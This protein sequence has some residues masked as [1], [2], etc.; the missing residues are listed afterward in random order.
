MIRKVI[1]KNF[2]RF[3]DIEFELPGHV[4]IAGPNNTGKTTFLQALASW[5][6]AF[7]RWEE[8]H[9]G[10]S[11][12]RAYPGAPVARQDFY[13]VPLRN[14]DL[15]WEDRNAQSDIEITVEYA[16]GETL[17]MRFEPNSSEQIYV[18]PTEATG[19]AVIRK[20][21]K[22]S[23]VFIPPMTGLGVE[24]PV[25]QKPK[26]NQL[27]GRG[28]P[29]EVLRNLLVEV[30]DNQDAWDNLSASMRDMFGYELLPPN[31]AGA[32]IRAEYRE[33]DGRNP[34]DI[35]GA[36]SGFQQV[37]ML[38]CFLY[39]RPASV[40]L[41]DE[42]DA[43]LHVIL[44]D[45]IYRK[46]RTVAAENDSQLIVSTHSEVVID[47]VE[48]R[49][50]CV[51]LDKPR[52]I[53]D[54]AERANLIRSLSV[55]SNTDIMLAANA[56]GILY[57]EGHTDRA[58]LLAWAKVLAHPAFDLLDNKLMWKPVVWENRPGAS[59]IKAQDHYDALTLARAGMPGLILL[60]GDDNANIPATEIT[61][62]G[63]QR[64]RW[65]RYEIESYLVHP[66]ALARFVLH[67]A[68]QPQAVEDMRQYFTDHFPPAVV[69]A[70]LGEHA[71]LNSTKARAELLPPLLDAAGLHGFPYTRYHEIAACMRP[72]EI[73]PEVRE[74]LDAMMAAVGGD[75]GRA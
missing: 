6:L 71:F 74:K 27:L 50:L 62:R 3:R 26:I 12:R 35:A 39:A 60:D 30:R 28:Q 21:R 65:R 51:L 11:R 25:Y 10:V 2:K 15:L 47:S 68:G 54:T 32:D 73:H 64:M 18:R 34:L 44:Q 38:L 33:S 8:L 1:I 57:V 58:I 45:A 75:D 37:L 16:T 52:A 42:P 53:A 7:Q 55:L 70:P 4:V 9:G 43:H 56:P 29:G 24:E 46:L 14:F 36:G 20:A 23:L 48:P 5:A 31:S 17:G 67:T 61:G 41:L 19:K 40:L 59:G 72:D 66:D 13:S 69:N 22:P 49:E 63:L